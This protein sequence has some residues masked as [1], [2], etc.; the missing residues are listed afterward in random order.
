MKSSSCNLIA[1]RLGHSTLTTAL[2]LLCMVSVSG[3]ACRSSSRERSVKPG[4]NKPYEHPDV[5]TWV[6]RFEGESREIFKYRHRIMEAVAARSGMVVAD[7]GAGTGLFTPFFSKA[8]GNK[9]AVWAVDIVPE[10]LELIRRRADEGGLT[11]VQTRLCAEDNVRLDPASVDLVF[12]SDTYHHFEYPVSTLASIH[13]ALRPGGQLVVIDF[14][15]IPGKS[16]DWVLDHVRA[17]KKTVI[18]EIR[19]AGFTLVEEIEA[20]YLEENYFLRFRKTD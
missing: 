7:V 16:R 11:N 12:V 2:A 19:S 13:E 6:K 5:D 18:E 4:I 3:L 1:G 14:E 17:D 9:G 20:P 10:F 15:R 8:V